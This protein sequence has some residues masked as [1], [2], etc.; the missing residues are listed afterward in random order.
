MNVTK[1]MKLIARCAVTAMALTIVCAACTTREIVFK[2]TA[3]IDPPPLAADIASAELADPLRS[4][5][6][7]LTKIA[8][9][10]A[11]TAGTPTLRIAVLSTGVDYN[12]EDLRGRIAINTT[13]VGAI[14]PGS[15]TPI[16]GVDDDNN[17][18]VDDIVGWDVVDEDGH[19]YDRRGQGT[20][21][22]GILAARRNNGLGI[23]GMMN[24]VRIY[25][26]R[27]IDDNGQ[28]DVTL[29]VKALQVA[30]AARVDLVVV[31]AANVPHMEDGV[32]SNMPASTVTALGAALTA[33]RDVPVV[34][35][36]GNDATL[37]GVNKIDDVFHAHDN[38]VVV[39]SSD[40]A[41]LKPFLSNHSATHVMTSAPGAEIVSTRPLGQYG[42]VSSTAYAATHVAGA[43]ALA[44]AK[45]GPQPVSKL[46]S[47]LLS[48][49]GSDRVAGMEGYCLGRN[50]LNVEKFL[51]QF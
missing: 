25:P 8:V 21:M 30:A 10:D 35:G 49:D 47:A 48:A 27:Y 29:L 44:I 20:A 11:A 3:T 23:A 51:S 4:Q 26:V 43:F 19:A 9:K 36:A 32:I 1:Q 2:P 16:N 28:S 40:V 37:F 45:A 50:R 38:V 41:D 33:L 42:T 14:A 17:G 46:V 5:Q 39:T 22:A 7:N 6:W 13:E 24:D 18:L 15:P 31:Q 12:H 34:I